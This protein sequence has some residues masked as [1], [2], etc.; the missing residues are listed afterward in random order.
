MI[1]AQH[2][3]QSASGSPTVAPHPRQRGGSTPSTTARPI[4]RN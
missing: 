1:A 4:R 3:P 2:D